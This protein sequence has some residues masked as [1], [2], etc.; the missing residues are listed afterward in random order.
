VVQGGIPYADLRTL[1]LDVGNTLISMDL[2]RVRE[3]L[4]GCGIR[5]EMS[6]LRRAEAAARPIVSA[7][8]QSGR[9]TEDLSGFEFYLRAI[10]RQ[11]PSAPD[12]GAK[13]R[14][15]VVGELATALLALG[16]QRL[17]SY[18]LPGV[19]E[20][21][22]GFRAAGLQLVVVSNSDGTVESVL[23]AQGLRSY[24]DLIFD[25][26]VVG[27]E[28]PDPQIF[29]LALK[30]CRA[31]P[32]RTLHVGDL[33]AADVVGARAAGIHALLLDPYGDWTGADCPRLPD[34]K[35]LHE[36]IQQARAQQMG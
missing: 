36:S 18:V 13:R 17:W 1:F 26:Q 5:C 27:F 30:R 21:L 14:D 12:P 8:L 31:A 7:A 24:F 28:K 32:D 9:S 34:L 10:L 16:K 2:A 6:A 25:S 3:E 33:Y 35:S 11:L 15:A 19:R 23:S 22:A 29:R 4:A 20:A